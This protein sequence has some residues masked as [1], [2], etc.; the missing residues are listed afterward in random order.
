MIGGPLPTESGSPRR[1]KTRGRG[2]A[3][4]GKPFRIEEHDSIPETNVAGTSAYSSKHAALD[5]ATEELLDAV[6]TAGAQ[7]LSDRTYQSA[8]R[9]REAVRAFMAQVL[10]DINDVIVSESGVNLLSRK[11]YFL[12]SEVNAKVDA[13]VRGV[14]SSQHE[15]VTIL[16]KLEEI[17]GLL[18]DFVH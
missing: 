17:E 6:H 1:S 12:L 8:Q 4:N 5:T 9:Y 3:S 14:L 2:A 18:V 11:R 10:P 7:L 16:A 13:L 15:Q